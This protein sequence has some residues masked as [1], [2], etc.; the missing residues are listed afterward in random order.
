MRHGVS[1]HPLPATRVGTY[2]VVVGAWDPQGAYL[3]EPRGGGLGRYPEFWAGQEAKEFAFL[4]PEAGGE[5]PQP[6]CGNGIHSQPPGA[7]DLRER[8]GPTLTQS[9]KSQDMEA[10]EFVKES[11]QFQTPLSGHAAGARDMGFLGVLLP[12]IVKES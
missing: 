12:A 9:T 4:Y 6:S 5:S 3:L 2:G 10:G 8:S 11:T 1:F 7:L